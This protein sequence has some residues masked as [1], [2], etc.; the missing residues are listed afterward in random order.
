MQNKLKKLLTKRSAA[1][2]TISKKLKKF[3]LPLPVKISMPIGEYPTNRSELK[4]LMKSFNVVETG[5]VSGIYIF[6]IPLGYR[7]K[8]ITQ[9]DIYRNNQSNKELGKRKATPAAN[10][11]NISSNVL[12]VGMSGNGQLIPRLSAHLGD[13]APRTGALRLSR[14][15][16]KEFPNMT[17]ELHVY[18]VNKNEAE[19]LRDI[20]KAFWQGLNPLSGEI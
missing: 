8:V 13:P 14:W 3:K 16:T 11:D 6:Q 4:K 1:L 9:L 17:L 18:I 7:K 19:L 20:E 2:E 10:H 5:N 15:L 12:Y